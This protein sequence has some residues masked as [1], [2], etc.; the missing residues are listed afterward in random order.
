MDTKMCEGID[1]SKCV[2][3]FITQRYMAKVTGPDQ[4]DNCQKE[5]KYATLKKSSALMVN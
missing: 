2:V 3:V 1:N 4:S 5:F